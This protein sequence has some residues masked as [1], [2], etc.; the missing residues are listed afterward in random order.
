M[1][2]LADSTAVIECG[3]MNSASA[4]PERQR[5][6]GPVAAPAA[7]M[8][9]PVGLPVAGLVVAIFVWAASKMWPQPPNFDG[10]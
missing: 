10:R 8:N 4:E 5:R 6:V 7:G 9:A 1:R 2:L 3:Y